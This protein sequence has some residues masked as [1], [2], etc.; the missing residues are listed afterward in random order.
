MVSGG[1]QPKFF[2]KLDFE[3]VVGPSGPPSGPTFGRVFEVTD[4]YVPAWHHAQISV[5]KI[6]ISQN[7]SKPGLWVLYG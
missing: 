6:A 7:W 4:P 3:I 5:P 2:G 1:V